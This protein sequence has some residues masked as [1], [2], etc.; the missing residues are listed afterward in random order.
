MSV[1]VKPYN[2]QKSFSY[3]KGKIITEQPW[4]RPTYSKIKE[5]LLEI[6]NTSDIM[7]DYDLYLIGGVLWDF[8]TTWDVDISMIGN[9]SSYIVLEDYMHY[10]YDTALNKYNLLIDISWVNTKPED[11][12]Y[13]PDYS[14]TF[15]NDFL[16]IGYIKK[17]IGDKFEEINLNDQ[18]NYTLCGDYLVKGNF[19]NKIMKESFIEKVKNNKNPITKVT[20]SVKEFLENDEEYFL[21]NTNR[22]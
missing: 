18:L 4:K 2:P 6:Q 14:F 22:P 5:F 19:K 15:D 20:F 1:F 3:Q 12:I 21:K 11:I 16:K 7:K 10:M 8:N 13:T 9:P 17:Q